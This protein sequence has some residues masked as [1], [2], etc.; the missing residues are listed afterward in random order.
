MTSINN[1]HCR[2]LSGYIYGGLTTAVVALPL[3]LAM[4]VPSGTGSIAGVYGAVFVGLFAA[5][6][7]GKPA[8]VSG[9]TGPMTVVMAAVFTS[10]AEV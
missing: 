6:F 5:L 1:I 8:Q 9:P 7:G 2:I 4:G 10:Y 3:A